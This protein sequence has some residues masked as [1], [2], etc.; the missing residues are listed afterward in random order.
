[1]VGSYGPFAALVGEVVGRW[2]EARIAAAVQATLAADV[3]L[4]STTISGDEGILTD[5][6]LALASTRKSKA[7]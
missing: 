4:K 1:M 7:A 6:T 5:L 3:A 2:S